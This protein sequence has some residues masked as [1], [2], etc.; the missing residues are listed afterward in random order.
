MA[1][2]SGWILLVPTHLPSENISSGWLFFVKV[3]KQ[4]NPT[5]FSG[6]SFFYVLLSHI[7]SKNSGL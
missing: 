6:H 2:K 3:E 7:V 4:A 1:A 5:G